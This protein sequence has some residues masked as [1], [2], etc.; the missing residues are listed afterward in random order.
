MARNIQEYVAQRIYELLSNEEKWVVSVSSGNVYDNDRRKDYCVVDVTKDKQKARSKA[1]K[2][3]VDFYSPCDECV[4][5][6]VL[7]SKF[8]SVY[9]E[10]TDINMEEGQNYFLIQRGFYG[11]RV[12]FEKI[13]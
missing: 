4:S 12:W 6:F 7:R 2:I 3:A 8:N 9:C 13:K 11:K 1:H 10:K 5:K